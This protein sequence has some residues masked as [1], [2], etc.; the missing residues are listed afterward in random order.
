MIIRL[1][2]TVG[3]AEHGWPHFATSG[4]DTCGA[5]I[6]VCYDIGSG[7]DAISSK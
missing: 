1:D 4:E 5:A 3:V 6:M 2:P 7:F